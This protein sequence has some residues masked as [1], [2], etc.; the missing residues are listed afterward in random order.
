MDDARLLKKAKAASASNNGTHA[1]TTCCA[2]RNT[3]HFSHDQVVPAQGIE[4]L[5]R[6]RLEVRHP[7]P[8][9]E[10]LDHAIRIGGR[11]TAPPLRHHRAYGS[12][13]R[14]FS[15]VK[16]EHADPGAAVRVHQNNPC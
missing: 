10:A 8:A 5:F 7:I 2:M 6:N 1:Q 14:R 15:K 13:P 12:V 9:C 11:L 16:C 3:L 4:A